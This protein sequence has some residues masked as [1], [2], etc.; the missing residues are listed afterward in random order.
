MEVIE[1]ML[2]QDIEKIRRIPGCR[3]GFQ[4]RGG[5][6]LVLCRRHFLEA[7]ESEKESEDADRPSRWNLYFPREVGDHGIE[8]R[9]CD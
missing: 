8:C 3:V 5:E 7:W 6:Y 4:G 1:E 2:P 9:W